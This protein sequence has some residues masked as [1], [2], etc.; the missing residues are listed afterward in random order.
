[1]RTERDDFICVQSLNQEGQ[2]G[3]SD[4]TN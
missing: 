2:V 1:M 4:G 3:K